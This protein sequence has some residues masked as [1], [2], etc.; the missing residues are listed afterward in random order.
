MPREVPSAVEELSHISLASALDGDIDVEEVARETPRSFTVKG[1]FFSRFV[2]R[3]GDGFAIVLPTL[4]AP[5]KMGRYMPFHDYPQSDYLRVMVALARKVHPRYGPREGVRRL[6]R[7]DFKVFTQST[8]GKVMVAM[9]GDARSALLKLPFVYSKVTNG[10]WEVTASEL[11]GRR[12][13]LEFR[14]LYG[15]WEYQLGQ[16]EGIVLHYGHSPDTAFFQVEPHWIR[17]DIAHGR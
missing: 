9:V 4:E 17:L 11:D 3:L 10:D 13:R 14:G 15:A 1:M 6:A 7:E 12:V 5:P 8:L 2:E 16:C